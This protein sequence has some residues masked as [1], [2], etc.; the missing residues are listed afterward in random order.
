MLAGGPR[1]EG[2]PLHLYVPEPNRG[3]WD[4]IVAQLGIPQGPPP[5]LRWMAGENEVV[6]AVA[7]DGEGIGLGSTLAL[8]ADLPGL[9]ARAVPVRRSASDTA[10]T[11]S[12]EELAA[13]EYPL[14]HY[15]YVAC[16]PGRG[17]LA[18]GFVTFLFS[19]RGQ[20]LVSR[21]G[22]VPAREVPRLVQ[23]VSQPIGEG[24]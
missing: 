23:L 20:R 3:L 11:A 1:I 15:V 7:N 8:P 22:Y 9:G 18:A 12:D 24:T 19:G 16:R 5:S 17:A 13:G 14:Y 10:F 6:E 21:L 4:G 2:D